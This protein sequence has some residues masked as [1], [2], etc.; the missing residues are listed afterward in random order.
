[1]LE[2]SDNTREWK[3]QLS[4]DSYIVKQ[5]YEIAFVCILIMPRSIKNLINY[6]LC[7]KHV[8][9]ILLKYVLDVTA[10]YFMVSIISFV[11]FKVCLY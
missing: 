7:T 1:M 10:K 2:D 5:C 9:M 4:Q 3:S 8:K 6:T 11:V